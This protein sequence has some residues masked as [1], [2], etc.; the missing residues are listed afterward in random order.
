MIASGGTLSSYTWTLL[1]INF[2]QTREHPILPVLSLKDEHDQPRDNFSLDIQQCQGFGKDNKETLGE[3]FFHFFRRYGHE[4][5]YET[6]VMSV[7]KGQVLTKKEKNWVLANNN[8]LCV[9]EP[10][11]T[12]RNLGNTADDTAF[13]G[14]HLELRQAFARIAEAKD[15]VS[16]VCEQFEYP[17]EEHKPIFERPQPA[18]RPIL[19]RSTSQSGRGNR[20]GGGR[21]GNRQHYDHRNQNGRR[22]SSAAA[23][24]P[25][26]PLGIQSPHLV[27]PSN[28][29]FLQQEELSRLSRAMSQ[30]EQQL[31]FRQFQI[32]QAQAF[33]ASRGT[34]SP[35]PQQRPVVN[36]FPSPRPSNAEPV[37][38]SAPVTSAYPFP[39]NFESPVTMSHSS[40]HQGTNTN[41]NSPMLA[42]AT[43]S[44]RG[45]Q[46]NPPLNSPGAAIRSQSQ[47]ARSM[48][49]PVIPQNTSRPQF[50]QMVYPPMQGTGTWPSNLPRPAY[51]GPY[52][53]PYGGY[54]LAVPTA[55]NLPR[56]Y[57]GYGIGSTP[58]YGQTLHDPTHSQP[59][60]YEDFRR[61]ESQLSPTRQPSSIGP[62]PLELPRSPSPRVREE[63]EGGVQSA[64]LQG[65]FPNYN[66]GIQ[67]LSRPSQDHTPMIVN[68]SYPPSARLQSNE[69]MNDDEHRRLSDSV[70]L[71]R[72]G[73]GLSLGDES[74]GHYHQDSQSS[75]LQLQSSAYTSSFDDDTPIAESGP[76]A[77]EYAPAI[78]SSEP[79]VV[80]ST[81]QMPA[82]P[83]VPQSL[84]SNRSPSF[85]VSPELTN[86]IR[87]SSGGNKHNIPP[88]DLGLGVPTS[89]RASQSAT[90][91]STVL[92]PVEETRTP[93]PINNRKH[94]PRKSV[95]MNGVVMPTPPTPLPS[96]GEK[97]EAQNEQQN[98][99]GVKKGAHSRASSVINLGSSSAQPA[100]QWQQ[101]GGSKKN[102][103]KSGQ[104]QSDAQD[105]KGKGEPLPAN[106]A[107]RKGG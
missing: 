53:G 105:K 24:G 79:A 83:S 44:R 100:G 96:K 80:R 37:A 87:R 84:D 47:P 35:V 1:V 10:F 43:P 94:L 45:F 36:G 38:G 29:Y 106:E 14:L 11:N 64:P 13:R 15:L 5:D 39:Q 103:K 30:E 93:S 6:A 49:P 72:A 23:F 51:Y 68:G 26:G 107:A 16:S 7:R 46:R 74:F 92:S 88:L 62:G 78:V 71:S 95:Q 50:G 57:L 61:Q 73:S 21:R 59:H 28:E 60:T 18:P 69:T 66:H 12:D 99:T 70:R 102:K 20:T 55:E 89:E 65:S 91:T 104:A 58:Q 56:E 48:P 63:L 32:M 25:T 75:D 33:A 85:Q 41:P 81:T 97:V 90:S 77:P 31:R 52:M 76:R 98:G 19:S 22:S 8:R 34:N 67:N 101:A 17:A 82:P 2:L 27:V 9:E 3:L 86:G 54:Y 4:I 42:P 40:S